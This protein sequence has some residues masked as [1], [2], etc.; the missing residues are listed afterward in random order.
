MLWATRPALPAT[1]VPGAGAQRTLPN[2]PDDTIRSAALSDHTSA[3][4]VLPLTV[5]SLVVWPVTTTSAAALP[6]VTLA[7]L[8]VWPVTEPTP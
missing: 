6:G 7:R 3:D 5:V 2:D 4:Y 8:V 1:L